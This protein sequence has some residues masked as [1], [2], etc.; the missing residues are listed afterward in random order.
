MAYSIAAT[1]A[2]SLV[3]GYSRSILA[4]PKRAW[5]VGGLLS[6]LYGFFYTLLREEEYSLLLGSIGLAIV[7]G[8]IMYISRKVDWYELSNTEIA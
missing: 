2:L 1:G 5:I 7:L 3:V 6:G 8:V 4:N